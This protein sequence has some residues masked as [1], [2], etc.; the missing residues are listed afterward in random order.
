MSIFTDQTYLQ[1][2][3]YKD[4][5]NLNARIQLH[6]RFSLNSYGWMFWIFDRFTLPD[7]CR[8]LDIGCGPCHLW[9]NNIERLPRGWE[10]T[11]SDFSAGMVTQGRA[12][13]MD[14]PHE[15]E[16]VLS[17]VQAL[18]FVDQIF[19]A[20]VANSMLYHI[21][22]RPRALAE[23]CRVLKP[24]GRLYAA[25]NGE[26]HMR[27]VRELLRAVDPDTIMTTAADEFGLE[28]GFEQLSPFF[29]AVTLHRYEDGLVVTEAQPLLDYVLSTNRS[30]LVKENPQKLARLIT[31]QLA[32][33]GS[34]YIAKDSGMF[35]AQKE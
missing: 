7:R 29:P 13:L 20:V 25:T 10:V 8:V 35:E 4:T 9:A 14:L 31:D 33:D 32:R 11:L 21:P 12:A 17:D 22:D 28:N 23:I 2:D 27:Q 6:R 30:A 24:G 3:Q 15:F 5:A 18:P 26:N 1:G 34:I 16:F 19:D